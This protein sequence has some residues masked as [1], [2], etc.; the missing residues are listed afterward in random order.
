MEGCQIK[1]SSSHSMW[2]MGMEFTQIVSRSKKELR[3]VGSERFE[4]HVTVATPETGNQ[5]GN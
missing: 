5:V 4:G 1:V 2:N 3:K